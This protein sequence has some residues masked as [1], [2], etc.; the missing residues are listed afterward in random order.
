MDLTSGKIC[1]HP[2]ERVRHEVGLAGDMLAG[3]VLGGRQ[4]LSRPQSSRKV[5]WR[6]AGFWRTPE[7]WPLRQSWTPALMGVFHYHYPH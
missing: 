5:W 2:G 4:K 3:E 7:N 6:K 1:V